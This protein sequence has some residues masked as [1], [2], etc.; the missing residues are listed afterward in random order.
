[1]AATGEQQGTN[2]NR[3]WN[4]WVLPYIPSDSLSID[5]SLK[6]HDTAD[7]TIDPIT[8]EVLRHALWNVNVEHGNTMMKISG[9]PIAYYGH[10]FNPVITDE[11]GDYV[12]YGPFLQYLASATGS[13]IKWTLENRSGNPGIGPGDMFLSND[14]WIASTHQP[15]VALFAPVFV[16]DALFCWVG[17]T[18]N[19]W[20]LGGTAPG[21]FNPAAPDAF[22]EPPCIPPIKI[23]EHGVLRRDLAEFYARLSRLPQLVSL[24][25]RAMIAGVRVATERIEHLIDRYGHGTLKASMKKLQDD[26]ER[27]FV[28]R[29]E[30][31][32]EGTWTAEGW[33]E[34]A[35]PG[36]R[37]VY[38]NRVT[39]TKR[40]DRLI[41]TNYGTHE[42]TG[43]ANGT[44]VAWRGAVLATLLSQML[45][46][47][48]CAIEGALRHCDFK[49]E[50]GTLSCAT[51]PA[52]VSSAPPLVLL[53]SIGLGELAISKMLACSSDAELQ[54]EVQSCMANIA[55]PINALSGLTEAGNP[56]VC[57]FLDAIGAGLPAFAWRDGQDTGG[58]SWDLQSTMPNVEEH[59]LFYPILYLWRKELPDS[60]GAGKFRGGNSGEWAF[61]M[62]NVERGLMDTVA[63]AVAV[64]GP[65]LFGGCPT[66]T[67]KFQLVR[68]THIKEALASGAPTPTRPEDLDGQTEWVGAKSSG[69]VITGDDVWI[70][71]WPAA[72]GYGDPLLRDPELVAAD[73]A[74]GRVSEGWARDGYGV[75]IGDGA[76]TQTLR[77][78]RIAARLG[79]ASAHALQPEPA[80]RG[81]PVSESLEIVDGMFQC[82]QC[83]HK[84]ADADGNFKDGASVRRAPASELNPQVR[85]SHLYT[86]ASV[87]VLLLSCPTCGVLLDAEISVA[88]AQPTWDTRIGSVGLEGITAL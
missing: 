49:V 21:G 48:M 13:A 74:A 50:P 1:M 59:E 72:S 71:S 80:L 28:Q 67:A 4:G 85:D 44:Y 69:N 30:T 77:A 42:Q 6:L 10:D 39:V 35:F 56:Y 17:N 31:I 79:H 51:W 55:F 84:L 63:S 82:R 83:G 16:G 5:P 54:T 76:A 40:D 3:E 86:D 33:M 64:P 75:V 88:G 34:G 60:G 78:E 23:V 57:V 46:D 18:L 27:A 45:F 81:R 36:D 2:D 9:S 32:P 65:G 14:P 29:L 66:S 26:S 52:S 15:D 20:D 43:A 8:H 87:E 7:S 38:R 58:Y 19:Q 61:T 47:Q 25:L 70:C 22:S 62:H 73:V 53:N 68:G 37:D 24:D 41:F 12:L 11:L